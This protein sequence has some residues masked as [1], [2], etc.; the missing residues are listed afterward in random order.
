MSSGP[1]R[2]TTWEAL[3]FIANRQISEFKPSLIY[4]ESF[5][6]ARAIQTNPAS[7]I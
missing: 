7:K 4:K 6:K 2:E 5:R 1:D 3:D